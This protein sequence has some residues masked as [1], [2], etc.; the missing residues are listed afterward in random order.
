MVVEVCP[1]L[2]QLTQRRLK[3]GSTCAGSNAAKQTGST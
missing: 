1:A 3:A 2:D